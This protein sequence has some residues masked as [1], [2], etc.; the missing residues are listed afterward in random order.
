MTTIRGVD[1]ARISDDDTGR[2][3][4]V[5]RQARSN[6]ELAERRRI[7]LTARFCDNSKSAAHNLGKRDEFRDMLGY[8][9]EHEIRYVIAW[10]P[11]RLLRSVAEGEEFISLCR[12]REVIVLTVTAGEFDLS[13]AYGRKAFR[14]AVNGASYESEHRGERVAEARADGARNGRHS[15]GV[16]PFGW[17]RVVKLY[18]ADGAEVGQRV[19]YTG[20]REDEAAEIRR[21][22]EQIL[23][24]VSIAQVT[25]DLNARGVKTAAQADGRT[26]KRNGKVVTTGGWN[27]RSI[28]QIL[29]SPRVSGHSVHG[30]KI[31]RRDAW[32]AILPEDTRQALVAIRDSAGRKTSPGNTPKWFGSLIYRC[33]VCDDGT[34]MA[35]R[36]RGSSGRATYVCRA[37]GHNRRNA[38]ELDDFVTLVLLRYLDE[39]GAELI[40]RPASGVDVKALR[41]EDRALVKRL[42]AK[43]VENALGELPDDTYAAVKAA[44]MQRRREIAGRLAEASTT[45]PV[46]K[47]VDAAEGVTAAWQ[48]LTVGEAR[49]VLREVLTVTV[50]PG[51][52]GDVDAEHIE[53]SGAA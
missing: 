17:G 9:S 29:T 36:Y 30:G 24:G 20:H 21:M 42:E 31:V 22:A 27:S 46:S 5:E 4:G 47:L 45:S 43:A 1:Y 10:H 2:A 33:G 49:E 3:A 26:I 35:V 13:T 50:L 37:H 48:V 39:H 11:D 41:T 32:P 12:R 38:V 16:R 44:V 18:D 19:D 6:S 15:G 51:F 40:A 7:Q 23:S 53:I 25:R 8:I 52:V 34:T 14:D 28:W